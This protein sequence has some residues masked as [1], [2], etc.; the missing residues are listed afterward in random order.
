MISTFR[1]E[2]A[3]SSF[4]FF[5]PNDNKENEKHKTP[6]KIKE[7]N[8]VF[9]GKQGFNKDDDTIKTPIHLTERNSMVVRKQGWTGKTKASSIY[10]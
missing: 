4:E 9:L 2:E 3:L 1:K 10:I 8:S 6:I 7:R 5:S